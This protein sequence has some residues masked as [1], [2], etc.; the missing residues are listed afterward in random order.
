MLAA[1]N[2]M[3]DC[4]A[5]SCT[6][7]EALRTRTAP[8]LS[9]MLPPFFARASSSASDSVVSTRLDEVPQR[10]LHDGGEAREPTAVLSVAPVMP[11]ASVEADSAASSSLSA[12]SHLGEAEEDTSE[13]DYASDDD[14]SE[15]DYAS[16]DDTSESDDGYEEEF[17]RFEL[18]RAHRA[19]EEMVVALETAFCGLR[20]FGVLCF[21]AFCCCDECGR[22]ELN[23]S[24][25]AFF[26]EAS[27]DDLLEGCP[28]VQLHYCLDENT[29][30][31]VASW[32]NSTHFAFNPDW[33]PQG[34]L[35]VSPHSAVMFRL[36]KEA[37][38]LASSVSI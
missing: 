38:L 29:L 32:A 15:S 6:F 10:G 37:D 14:T 11:V 2:A 9:P 27:F 13:S 36:K 12:A 22:C 4:T 23:Y 17:A 26:S 8:L 1:V 31:K 7:L 20:S 34:T 30:K 19:D 18:L 24:N 35:I 28:L 21:A 5:A 3:L 33:Q 16:D 25:Y